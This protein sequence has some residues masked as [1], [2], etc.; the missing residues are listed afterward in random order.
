LSKSA[1]RRHGFGV[2]S[3]SRTDRSSTQWVERVVT[4]DRRATPAEVAATRIDF[5]SWLAT[6]TKR[7]R[8]IAK[9]L[10]SGETTGGAAKRFTVTAGRISQVWQELDF[11]RRL[12]PAVSAGRRPAA[13]WRSAKLAR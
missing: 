13:G 6:L 12:R 3:L 8:L 9:A 7:R 2:L 10:A 4:Q 11:H 5:R 1:Q